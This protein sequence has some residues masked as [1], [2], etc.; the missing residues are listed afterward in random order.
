MEPAPSA[1]HAPPLATLRLTALGAAFDAADKA[2]SRP[3]FQLQLPRL[4]ELALTVPAQWCG[5][6][7]AALSLL[8]LLGAVVATHDSVLAYCAGA[9][10]LNLTA[11]WFMLLLTRGVRK[12][13]D[14][15]VGSPLGLLVAP[16]VTLSFLAWAGPDKA[17]AAGVVC[18]HLLLHTPADCGYNQVGNTAATAVALSKLA[19]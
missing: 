19:T 9:V 3:V 11:A 12:G 8:P 4:A 1:V 6:P 13:T 17:L 10:A 18:M 14:V 2:I 5:M 16:F 7:L 15:L